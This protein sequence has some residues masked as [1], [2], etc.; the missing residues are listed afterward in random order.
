M[1]YWKKRKHVYILSGILFFSFNLYYIFLMQDRHVAYLLYLDF[2]LLV[3]ILIFF[4]VDYFG[5]RRAEREKAEI[6]R[7]HV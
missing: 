6:G 7:A 3:L 4:V 1:S 2:L 5:Y